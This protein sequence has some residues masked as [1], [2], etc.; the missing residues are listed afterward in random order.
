M[1]LEITM[2][3][4]LYNFLLLTALVLWEFEMG[5]T[6]NTIQNLEV[7]FF[8][9]HFHFMWVIWHPGLSIYLLYVFPQL[10]L[11]LKKFNHNRCLEITDVCC[12]Y[13]YEKLKKNQHEHEL[14]VCLK[15]LCV[16]SYFNWFH[17]TVIYSRSANFHAVY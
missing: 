14:F 8:L 3:H 4:H 12:H 7:V 15:S 6:F 13:L 16:S 9:R 10:L 1:T 11:S 2:T 5:I 17:W